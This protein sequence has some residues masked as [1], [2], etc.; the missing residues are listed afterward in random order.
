ME[1]STTNIEASPQ[2]LL[3]AMN[4][5]DAKN[6]IVLPPILLKRFNQVP[7]DEGPQEVIFDGTNK[8]ANQETLVNMD[9]LDFEDLEHRRPPR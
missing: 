6:P 3:R 4:N 1:V 8:N 9:D 5:S 2:V 7:N